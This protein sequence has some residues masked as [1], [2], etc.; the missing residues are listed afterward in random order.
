MFFTLTQSHP[1]VFFF[2]QS[3]HKI[4]G[5]RAIFSPDRFI[6]MNLTFEYVSNGISMILRLEGGRACNKFEHCNTQRPEINSLIISPSEIDFRRKKEV[7]ANNG[8]H[9]SPDPP[10]KG[11]LGYA[12][13]NNFDPAILLV[14]QNILRFDISMTDIMRV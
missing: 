14:I 8:Q 5:K 7:S 12:K 1:L 10:Q 11:L 9:I 13:I 6:V 2:E 3:T 4:F